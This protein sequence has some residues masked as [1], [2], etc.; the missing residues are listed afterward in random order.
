MVK[1]RKILRWTIASLAAVAMVWGFSAAKRNDFGMGRNM[2]IMINLMR[3]LQTDY[4][5]PIDPDEV[6]RN[7]A[8][9]I[10]SALDP[11]TTYLPEEE[12][13]DFTTMTTGKYGGIGSMIRQD[14]NYVRIAEPYKGSPADRAGLQIGDRIVAIDGKSTAGKTTADVSELLR[15][16]PNTTVRVTVERLLDGERV[17]KKIRRERISIPSVS[18]VGYVEPGTG[19]IRHSDFTDGCYDE[20]RAAVLRLQSEGQLERLIL[21]YRGNGGG[22]MQSAV[23]VLSLFLPKGTQVL[24]LKGRA[25]G[26]SRTF[27]TEYE[28]LLPDTPLAVLINSNSASAAEIVAGALQDLDR[29]VIIGQRSF[30]KGLVQGTVHLGYNS[31]LK[32]TTAKYYIPSGRCIQATRYSS[33]GRAETLPDSLIAEFRTAGGRKV[34]DGGGITPDKQTEPEYVSAF[35]VTLYLLGV[36]D[37]FGD[38]YFRRHATESLDPR[39]FSIT[40]ADYADFVRMVEGRDIPYKSDSRRALERLRTALTKERYDGEGIEQAIEQIDNR[41]RDDKLSNLTT[42]RKEIVDAIND[43]IILRYA[44]SEGV[45][46]KSLADDREVSE[47]VKV[48]R[49]GVGAVLGAK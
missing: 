25:E 20:M 13:S 48:L 15:G 37:D 22:V 33:D 42:Y 11:Y 12:M 21:D 40:D 36:I 16:E 28:P 49:E 35:A 1:K 8:K 9:G 3:A 10:C 14:S 7:G 17:E 26:E 46:A 31:F 30:G 24:S 4:V 23:K 44:Y 32:L 19:Y 43:N 38:D 29:A 6:M 34:Y 45:I 5:E 41:L 47:A 18:Y 39:T 27:H 2:E